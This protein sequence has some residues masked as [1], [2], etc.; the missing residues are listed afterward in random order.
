MSCWAT[1]VSVCV[2]VCVCVNLKAFK[3]PP[4]WPSSLT[5]TTHTFPH[6]LGPGRYLS[7]WPSYTGF[8]AGSDSKESACNVGDPGLIPGPVRSPGEGHG[9]P[10]QYSCLGNPMD[11]GA[12]CAT[13]Y[14]VT[15]LD[16]TEWLTPSYIS[17]HMWFLSFHDSSVTF[18]HHNGY[19]GEIP[20]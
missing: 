1:T 19:H 2:W 4:F 10:C 6:L 18:L 20:N 3:H 7:L 17:K 11:R 12:Q 13:V 9:Y 5:M 16:R 14:R 8:P 15:G